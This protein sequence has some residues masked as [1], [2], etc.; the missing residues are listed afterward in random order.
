MH[1][2]VEDLGAD[3]ELRLP[4]GLTQGP[5][6]KRGA[7]ARSLLLGLCLGSSGLQ[8]CLTC[9]LQ[10]LAQGLLSSQA[11]LGCA[12]RLTL[13]LHQLGVEFGGGGCLLGLAGGY[14]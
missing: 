5:T 14:G 8:D 4:G 6:P 7:R 9:R 3:L 2:L 13:G 11:L 1:P 12:P 10:G